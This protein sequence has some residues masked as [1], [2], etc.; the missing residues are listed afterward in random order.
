MVDDATVSPA[1]PVAEPSAR[2]VFLSWERFR[3]VYNVV[4]ACVVV[5]TAIVFQDVSLFGDGG[6]WRHLA[7]RAVLANLCFGAGPW[8]EGWLRVAG[9]RG[10]E[11]RVA[12]FLMGTGLAVLGAA[13]SVLFYGRQLD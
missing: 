7:V 12:L 10:N 13:A 1:R 8:V 4:L 9:E 3:L 5:L 6:F 11:A 2:E